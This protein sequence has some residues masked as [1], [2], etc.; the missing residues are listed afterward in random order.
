MRRCARNVPYVYVYSQ[1][2]TVNHWQGIGAGSNA[3]A[4]AN[5][6]SVAVCQLSDRLAVV[7]RLGR[8]RHQRLVLSLR[9]GVEHTGQHEKPDGE[10][11]DF[12]EGYRSRDEPLPSDKELKCKKDS[13]RD[14]EAPSYT[15]RE[16]RKK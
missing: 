2:C 13:L 8:S 1:Y 14:S 7:H 9:V 15:G 11:K 6:S 3:A 12:E 10:D 4:T 5:G 16:G